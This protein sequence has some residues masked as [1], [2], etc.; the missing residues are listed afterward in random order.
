MI[1]IP[2]QY[3]KDQLL[4]VMVPL[5]EIERPI[6]EMR[7]ETLFRSILILIFVLPL[8]ATLV[9]VWIDRRLGRHADVEKNN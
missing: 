1:E 8:Y 7:N 2:P 9:V 6:I 5:Q 3:G 4:A